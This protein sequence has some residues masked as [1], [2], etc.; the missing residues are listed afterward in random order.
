MCTIVLIQQKIIWNSLKKKYKTQVAGAKKFIVGKFL[1]YKMVD[2]K[3]IINQVRKI[4][5]I[6]HDIH[7]ENMILSESF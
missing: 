3:T 4:Q 6:I 5:G 7:A 1:D 2:S